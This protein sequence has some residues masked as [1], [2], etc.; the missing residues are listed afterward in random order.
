MLSIRFVLLPIAGAAMLC[1]SALADTIF[2]KTG[3]KLEG[4]ILSE[5]ATEL[6]IEVKVSAGVTD[7]TVVARDKV[8][9]VEKEQPDVLAWQTLKNVKLGANSL[10]A[11]QYDAVMRPLQGFVTSYPSS[12]HLAEA[13]AK[14]AAFAEEKKRVDGGEVRLGEKWLS[15]EEVAKERYQINATLSYQYLRGQSAAGDFVGALNSFEQIDKNYNGASVYP[16]AV[17]AAKSAL[18]GLKV[19]VDR[20]QKNYQTLQAEFSQGVANAVEP[21]KSELIAARQRELAQGEAAIAGA[22][23]QGLKW[24]PLMLRSDKSIAA[25]AQK[26]PSEQQRLAALEVAKMR[27][28]VKLAEQA[29]KEIADLKADAADELL[30]KA[31][32]LWNNNELAKRL[33]PELATLRATA[34]AAPAAEPDAT[35][36]AAA[37]AAAEK[38]VAAAP[39][40][41]DELVIEHEPE[42]PF[43]LTP[44]GIVTALVILAILI[45]GGIAYNKIR[46]K[47][48]DILE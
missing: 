27:D 43:F 4:K 2:L 37:A 15:K 28:S 20:A 47:A 36:A 48:S 42:K 29:K 13:A 7:Q 23:R 44:G 46:H 33:Q 1:T 38:E 31:T 11:A 18:N 19:A 35:A 40:S 6:T 16:D 26:I 34:T 41:S 3:E 21:Q 10:P 12:P 25:L 8:D 30:R 9:K 32:E 17:D 14:L 5:T 45:A 39:S 24:P 22:E